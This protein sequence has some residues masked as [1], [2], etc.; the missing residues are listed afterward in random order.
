[1]AKPEERIRIEVAFEGGQTIGGLIPVAGVDALR[2]ALAAGD[3]VFDLETEDGTYVIALQKVVY[4][5]RYS[6]ETTIGFGVA[7]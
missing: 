2:A 3:G 5:K 4:V 1:M 7:L 6:R